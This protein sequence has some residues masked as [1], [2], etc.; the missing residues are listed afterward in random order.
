MNTCYDVYKN[1]NIKLENNNINISPCCISPTTT[2][3]AIDFENDK[4]LNTIREHW[5]AEKPHSACNACSVAEKNN[6][7]SRRIGSNQWYIENNCANSKVELIRLD[8]WTGDLCN[9]RCAIC[10]PHSSSAWKQELNI[11]LNNRKTVI[12]DLW[13]KLDLSKLKYIHFNG[14]EPLLSKE[15]ITFLKA[16]P[17]KSNVF[18]NYNT[19]GTVIPSKELFDLWE[20][21][22]LVQLDFS[23]DDI[24]T[25]FNYQRFPASWDEVVENL[26]YFK[27]NCS[28]NCMFAVNTS[29]GILNY[30]NYHNLLSWLKLNFSTNRVTDP[31]QYRTQLTHGI[32]G[33]ENYKAR[34]SEIVNYLDSLDARRNTAWRDIFPEL[35]SLLEN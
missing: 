31:V 9:L 29:L 35:V 11:P 1:I 15:H 6:V 24:G 3:E 28:V 2:V 7:S 8:F 16:I 18:I 13:K 14:G 22:K 5:S 10:G 19:N 32:L 21:F 26:N 33:S 4:Y 25:R 20:Q 23:I 12:N 34:T 27:N 17:V 30:H